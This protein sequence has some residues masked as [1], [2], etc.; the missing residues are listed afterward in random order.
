MKS[1]SPGFSPVITICVLFI[2]LLL[3]ACGS[4]R[5]V[6]KDFLYFLDGA[7]TASIT[8][9]ETIIQA[10]DLLRIQVFSRSLNQE[11]AAIFNIPVQPNSAPEGYQVNMA[12]NLDFPVI[13]A[14]PAA[15]LTKA[16]LQASLVEKLADYVKNPTVLIRFLQFNVNVLGEVR[17]PGTQRFAVDR[18]TI[19]DAISAAGDLTDFG[20]REDVTVIREEKGK[21]NY[22]TID[23]RSRNI[24]KSP[25]YILQPNDIVYVGPN[26]Y[27]L[28]RMNIDPEAERRTGLLFSITSVILSIGS[29]IVFSLNNN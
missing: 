26:K 10:N 24:F 21:K 3:T 29:L 14:V 25:V 13:G 6:N 18:V 15:G 16:Q 23:L 20:K 8:Q 9:K 12:G 22:H 4:S 11:Q 1:T 5:K 2:V 28:K 27:K 7:D 17:T 19:I